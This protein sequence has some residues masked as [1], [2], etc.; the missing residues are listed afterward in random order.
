MIPSSF[1]SVRFVVNVLVVG[2][3][4]STDKRA[5]VAIM[6]FDHLQTYFYPRTNNV[7]VKSESRLR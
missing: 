5:P 1:V 3:K 7:T 6:L 2:I 4:V